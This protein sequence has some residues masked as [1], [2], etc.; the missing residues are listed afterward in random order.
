MVKDGDQDPWMHVLA[1]VKAGDQDPW[2]YAITMVKAN[3]PG[4]EY[5]TRVRATV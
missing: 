4:H 3:D 5:L 2:V 1:M